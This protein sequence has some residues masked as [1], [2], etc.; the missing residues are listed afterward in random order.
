MLVTISL[1]VNQPIEEFY[2]HV[3]LYTQTQ[4]CGYSLPKTPIYR[5]P[6]LPQYVYVSV[7]LL[8]GL[9]ILIDLY[10][11]TPHLNIPRKCK[12]V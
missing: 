7:I 11:P 2:T 9:L 10:D 4:W 1:A 5:S 3:A 6:G 8:I 12:T